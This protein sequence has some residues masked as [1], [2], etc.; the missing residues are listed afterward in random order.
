MAHCTQ[1][2][3]GQRVPHAQIAQAAMESWLKP[4]LDELTQQHLHSLQGMEAL[5]AEHK[6][7][8]LG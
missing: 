6:Q 2:V 8:L 1:S 7:W 3:E 4:A 5:Q